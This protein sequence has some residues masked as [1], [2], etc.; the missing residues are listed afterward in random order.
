[1]IQSAIAG[2]ILIGIYKFLDRNRI[3]ED[4]DPA[5]DWWM[6][7]VFVFTPTILIFIL[8]MGLGLAELPPEFVLVGYLFY[9]LVPFAMLKGMLDFKLKRAIL[10][11]IWVPIIAILTDVFFVALL[12]ASSA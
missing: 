8:A 1:M 4:F 12:G 10:F 7:F 6:A 9:F 5:V 2:L 11:S 3:P